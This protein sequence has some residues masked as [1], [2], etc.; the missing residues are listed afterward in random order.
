MY[1]QVL[2]NTIKY[3]SVKLCYMCVVIPSTKGSISKKNKK[4]IGG[5][6]SEKGEV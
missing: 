3:Q 6:G 2:V 4:E 5:G 1:N